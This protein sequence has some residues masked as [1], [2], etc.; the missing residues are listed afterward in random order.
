MKEK[1]GIVI[2]VLVF[3]VLCGVAFYFMEYKVSYY[4]TKIDNTKVR[5]LDSSSDMKYEYELPC[6]NERGKRRK[7]E[8]KTSRKLREGAYLKLKVL[9]T[10][11][12][13]WEEVQASEIPKGL[14]EKMK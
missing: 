11:V 4:Y 3:I 9:I 6:Y 10:G 13:S 1:L 5:T 12:N 2:G 7:I 14:E 8:F